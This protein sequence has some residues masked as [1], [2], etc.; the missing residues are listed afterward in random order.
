[1]TI[2]IT[3]AASSTPRT[4]A[5]GNAMDMAALNPVEDDELEGH[6]VAGPTIAANWPG[7]K[8]PVEALALRILGNAAPKV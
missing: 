7:A 8:Y 6:A 3:A 2:L 1:L 4:Q 5:D